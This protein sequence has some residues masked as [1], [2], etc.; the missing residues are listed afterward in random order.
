[1]FKGKW[2]YL[3]AFCTGMFASCGGASLPDNAC[4]CRDQEEKAVDELVKMESE[5]ARFDPAQKNNYRELLQ[6]LFAKAGFVDQL[7][8]HCQVVYDHNRDDKCS[9]T[10][11]DCGE[12]MA[13]ANRAESLKKIYTG[14][15]VKDSMQLHTSIDENSPENSAVFLSYLQHKK[16]SSWPILYGPYWNSQNPDSLKMG[17]VYIKQYV[18]KRKLEVLG[19]FKTEKEA[20]NFVVLQKTGKLDVLEQYIA[21]TPG[22]DTIW[23]FPRMFNKEKTSR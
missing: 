17:T 12:Y 21:A 5:I 7:Y 23:F 8:K 6:Q 18:V 9:M 3:I 16:Y 11:W 14:D 2:I 20:R 4:A 19:V 10:Y 1:M 13:A 15:W 22:R